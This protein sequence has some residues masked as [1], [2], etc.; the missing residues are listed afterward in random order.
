MLD[1]KLIRQDPDKVREGL[2]KKGETAD[3]LDQLLALDS[4]RR[5]MLTEVEKLKARRNEVSDQIAQLKREKKDAQSLIEDMRL[6]SQQ[7][8]DSDEELRTVDG[9]M[10]DLLLRIPNLPHASA[11]VGTS[12][13][14]NVEVRRWGEPTQFDFE[15]LPTG[16]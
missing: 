2:A 8:K 7:I 6:V 15:P 14:D 10:Q 1:L 11:P 16:S 5:S 12:E 3:Y 4:R 9:A 13:D